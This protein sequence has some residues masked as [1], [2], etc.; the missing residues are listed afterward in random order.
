MRVLTSFEY[1]VVFIEP[2]DL[3]TSGEIDYMHRVKDTRRSQLG[4]KLQAWQNVRQLM[5]L[6]IYFG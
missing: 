1:I 3:Q 5:M 4:E 2:H 6:R